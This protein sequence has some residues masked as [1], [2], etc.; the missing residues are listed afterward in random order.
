MSV[1]P[2]FGQQNFST[3]NLHF[4]NFIVVALPTKKKTAVWT[5]F[6]SAPKAPPPSKSEN[7]IFIVVSPSLKMFFIPK[8]MH[9]TIALLANIAAPKPQKLVEIFFQNFSHKTWN[10]KS[11]GL[12][13]EDLWVILHSK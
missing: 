2:K 5:I 6:L 4:Q 9:C 11:G 1:I 13:G 12:L 8:C 3:I 7:F 10:D